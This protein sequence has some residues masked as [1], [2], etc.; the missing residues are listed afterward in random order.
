MKNDECKMKNEKNV[1]D[2]AIGDGVESQFYILHST[3]VILCA[4]RAGWSLILR[5]TGHISK[6]ERMPS[7][8]ISWTRCR[9]PPPEI[10]SMRRF[11]YPFGFLAS[12]LIIQAAKADSPDPLRLLPD[13]ADLCVKLEQ[14]RA[15]VE[16]IQHN[17]LFKQFQAIETVREFYGS[18]NFRRFSQLVAYFERELGANYPEIVDRLAGG[19]VAYTTQV[20]PTP[21]QLLVIQGRDEQMLQRF[22]RAAYQIF[23]QELA[24]QEAKVRIEKRNYRN[25]ETIHVRNEFHIAVVGAALVMSN[26]EEALHTAIDLSLNHGKGSLSKIA[27]PSEAH[28]LVGTNAIAW[29]WFKLDKPHKA[30]QTQDLFRLPRDSAALTVLAGGML[31][32]A[33]RSPFLCAGLHVQGND[34][35]LKIRMPAGRA[36]MPEGLEIA[37]PRPGR[38]ALSPLLEPKG[39]LYSA[40]IFLDLPKFW[41]KRAKLFNDSQVKGLEQLDKNSAAIMAGSP[42]SKLLTQTGAN[43]RIV[44]AHQPKSA[45]Q[46]VP[47]QRIPSF[48]VILELNDPEAFGKSIE[49]TLRA[50][51]LLA[52]TQVK[53]KA[54]EE[55]HGDVKIVGY[56]FPEDGRF[57][58]DVDNIRFNFSPCFEGRETFHTQLDDRALPG[59]VRSCEKRDGA[60]R[61]E[62][63]GRTVPGAV[64]RDGRRGIA[65]LLPR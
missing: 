15:L 36:G 13:Q 1:A 7:S 18:T 22:V 61:L 14:P 37:V 4:W 19:G 60:K 42:L 25:L 46:I 41:E 33:A 38:P 54:V 21:P 62:P 20:G 50:A 59:I 47:G 12:L 29:M 30:P 32:V 56:R 31:D 49:A 55:K 57:E 43:H 64:L 51:A 34:L 52:T 26:N 27:G 6:P 17:H 40:S 3:F 44:V 48:A 65:R 11:R 9:T 45:Y 10:H 5:A 16:F 2:P 23:E 53:L 28:K 58:P 39:V 24:R 35:L 63:I 8:K